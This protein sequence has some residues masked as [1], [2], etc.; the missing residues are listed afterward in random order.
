MEAAMTKTIYVTST[1]TFSGKSAL[2]VVLLRRF[3]RDGLEIGYMKPVSTTARIFGYQTLDEDALL[4]KRSFGLAEPLETMTPVVLTEQKI[5][6]V[7][8]G[9]EQDF[10]AAVRA[11]YE[12]IAEGKD[13]LV[14]EGGGSLREGWIVNLAPPHVADLLDAQELVVVPYDND[15]QLVDDLITARSRLGDSCLGAVVNRVPPQRLDFVKE[16]V[17]PFV[18]R[19]GVRIYAV[20]RKERVLLSVSVA[21]LCE[22]LGGKVLSAQQHLEELVEHLAVGAMAVEGALS[23][24]RRTPNKAVITGGDRADI[25]LAALET[26]TKC[27]ILTGNMWPDSLIIGRAEERGVPIILTALDTMSAIER[28]ERFFGK[29]RFH[30]LKKIECFEELLEK[31]MDYPALYS[32]LGLQSGGHG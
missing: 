23:H 2:C 6:E 21:E 29:T 20:L 9:Q 8:A 16:Q 11:S 31:N 4:I 28:I 32:A 30:L 24:F 1:Q 5:A 3:Q 10:A 18:E 17:K 27:L 12:T 26:S 22:G 25:Q 7:L 13:V 15:L 14:L 19:H